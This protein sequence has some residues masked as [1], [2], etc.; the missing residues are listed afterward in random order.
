M[1]IASA[2]VNSRWYEAPV[3]LQKDLLVLLANAQRGLHLHAIP[4]G[5]MSYD[6]YVAVNIVPII[7]FLA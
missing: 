1:N 3:E 2:A 6:L 4:I 5:V 7:V